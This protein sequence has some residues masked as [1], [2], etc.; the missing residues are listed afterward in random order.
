MWEILIFF[1]S[2]FFF[3]TSPN[4][5]ASEFCPIYFFCQPRA[6]FS[7]KF[8]KF[9]NI[10][11][12]VFYLFLFSLMVVSGNLSQAPEL[13][14]VW[15][16]EL[17]WLCAGG[18]TV[19]PLAPPSYL[20]VNTCLCSECRSLLRLGQGPRGSIDQILLGDLFFY[21]D[22]FSIRRKKTMLWSHWA[23]C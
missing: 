7:P 16:F 13:L 21:L 22:F 8:N 9:S 5:C 19:S 6:N 10:L 20:K 2:F 3:S 4:F 1:L 18:V 15:P 23:L 14:I 11:E 17:W 12:K